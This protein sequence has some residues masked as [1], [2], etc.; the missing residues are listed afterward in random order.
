MENTTSLLPT[1]LLPYH[2]QRV[3]PKEMEIELLSQDKYKLI[4]GEEQLEKLAI[5]RDECKFII[6]CIENLGTIRSNTLIKREANGK[7]PFSI[8][9][10]PNAENVN[11]ISAYILFK[12]HRLERIGEGAFN[13]ITLAWDLNKQIPM[14]FRTTALSYVRPTELKINELLSKR[15]DLFVASKDFFC[16]YGSF[17]DRSFWEPPLETIGNAFIKRPIFTNSNMKPKGVKVAKVGI[18]MEYLKCSL[19]SLLNSKV[20]EFKTK[21]EIANRILECLNVLHNEFEIVHLD[22]KLSNILMTEEG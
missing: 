12:K 3:Y 15:N 16:Y 17:S 19:F 13:S 21:I 1:T 4:P 14:I 22:L 11:K 9:C 6:D 10:T 2:T 5:T 8:A 18:I 20:P 7:P